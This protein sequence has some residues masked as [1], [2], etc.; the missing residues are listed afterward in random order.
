MPSNVS[1]THFG[2][3]VEGSG[4]WSSSG[5]KDS[6]IEVVVGLV[7]IEVKVDLYSLLLQ[8]VNGFVNSGK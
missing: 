8:K 4:C 3:K 7:Y 6:N 2:P 5:S 1:V